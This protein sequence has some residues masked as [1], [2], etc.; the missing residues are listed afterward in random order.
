[1]G[2]G[3]RAAG[4]SD[5]QEIHQVSFSFVL[6]QLCKA[7]LLMTRNNRSCKAGKI[8][9]ASLMSVSNNRSDTDIS[10]A[11]RFLQLP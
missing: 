9:P 7:E 8:L 6:Q 1:M 10:G 2:T 4:S 5:V 3:S 11:M